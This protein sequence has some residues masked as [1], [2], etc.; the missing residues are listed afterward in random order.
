MVV[1][2]RTAFDGTPTRAT[3]VTG[4]VHGTCAAHAAGAGAGAGTKL[5]LVGAFAEINTQCY[6]LFISNYLKI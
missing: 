6:V 5:H 3:F 1:L 2:T 4:T